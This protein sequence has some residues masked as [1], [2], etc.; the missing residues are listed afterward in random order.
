M[1]KDNLVYV[2]DI[3]NSCNLIA[4]Y[5]DG[6]EFD[7]MIENQMLID[8][9]IRNIEVIGEAANKLDEEFKT[10]NPTFPIRSA[11][12]M[13]NKLIHDYN[14]IDYQVVWDTVRVDIPELKQLCEEL[15]KN[16]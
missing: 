1:K 10:R 6:V 16:L 8:A 4:E 9:V 13:R 15:L 3:L 14:E 2:E 5:T 7:E 11:V 12:T